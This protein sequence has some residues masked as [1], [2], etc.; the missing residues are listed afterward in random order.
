[1]GTHMAKMSLGLRGAT[2]WVTGGAVL[3]AT[4]APAMAR[5]EE[6]TPT[7]KGIAG[8]VLLGAEVVMGVEAAVGVRKPVP[9]LVGGIA[10]GVLGGVGG[11]F[12]EQNVGDAKIPSY[13]LAA[14]VA[15]L[16]PATVLVFD[17][18]A[19]RPPADYQEDRGGIDSEPVADAPTAPPN[20]TTP[21]PSSQPPEGSGA[22]T[23]PAQGP[24]SK[25]PSSPPR[26]YAFRRPPLVA[27]PRP[28]MASVLAFQ[29]S[30]LR[31][32]VP[33]VEI[34]PVFTPQELR[35]LG[36]AQREE[37]RIPVFQARF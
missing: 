32:S 18:T 25:K 11:Y 12:L 34:R 28:P 37:V 26:P 15:L 2:G 7:G 3:L 6:S 19:Y 9:F 30:Q 21:P 5:A 20:G 16:I 1:M 27:P 10:G 35:Q 13:L 31:L 29:G 17:A 22:G 24:V 8:G 33:A 4:L 23:L 14:G 36:V